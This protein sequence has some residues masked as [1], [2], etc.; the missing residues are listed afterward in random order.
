MV[1]RAFFRFV[2]KLIFVKDFTF[3]RNY[4][5]LNRQLTIERNS[6]VIHRKQILLF[7]IALKGLHHAYLAL[8]PLSPFERLAHFDCVF[9]IMN[10][11]DMNLVA[12]C[13]AFMVVR[14]ECVFYWNSSNRRN[15]QLLYE[16]LVQGRQTQFFIWSHYHGKPVEELLRKKFLTVYNLLQAFLFSA[17]KFLYKKIFLVRLSLSLVQIR[18]ALFHYG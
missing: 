1:L 7:L 4:L 3:Y 2:I 12:T 11:F 5:Q 16:I 18:L 8:M 17:S 6:R 15:D 14:L 13:C 10:Q 9:F